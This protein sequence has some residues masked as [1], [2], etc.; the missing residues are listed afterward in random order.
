MS[1]RI[2]AVV[3]SVKGLSF[4]VAWCDG[5]FLELGV[6]ASNGGF[7]GECEV[8]VTSMELADLADSLRGF[9]EVAG[10]RRHHRLGTFEAHS[11]GGG[12]RLGCRASEQ[13]SAARVDLELCRFGEEASLGTERARFRLQVARDAIDRFV[14][15]L[16][17]MVSNLEPS[18]GRRSATHARSPALGATAF[19]SAT[20]VT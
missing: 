4:E 12:L 19:L 16:D 6:W 17:E 8:Y 7:T 9:P 15:E 20:A 14:S 13:A 3:D 18:S 11:S 5:E 2:A 1:G 10:E